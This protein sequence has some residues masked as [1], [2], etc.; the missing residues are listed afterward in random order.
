[1]IFVSSACVKNKYI[2][3]SV[4]Q[5]ADY[6]FVNIELSGGTQLYETLQA[7]LLKLKKEYSLNY[8]CH[9]YFPPPVNPFVIN[10]ASLDQEIFDLS[11]KHIQNAIKLSELLGAEKYGF[12]AG[13][14]INIPLKQVGKP[15]EKQTLFDRNIA[16]Q[17]FCKSFNELQKKYP[18]V[19]LY[20]ENNV[21]STKNLENFKNINPF[22]M[23]DSKGYLELKQGIDFGLILDVA[24]LKVSC[25]SLNLNFEEELK[26][27]FS[28][29]DY[30][31]ISDN[32]G[33]S[34]SNGPFN[35]DSQL[36]KELKKLDFK[37]KISTVEVYGSMKD[38]QESIEAVKQ[39]YL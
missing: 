23:C 24:H 18:K 3:E 27:L 15:I 11:F 7:D 16:L 5:L 19:Q 32:D 13:F 6:G 17:Q 20:L 4:K 33:L 21:L 14:L 22:F 9:N 2:G 34:D 29:S 36:F 30:I 26:Q 31:H 12:H 1:M 35:Q 10:L 8:L 37:N 39:L 25:K 28:A 38:I